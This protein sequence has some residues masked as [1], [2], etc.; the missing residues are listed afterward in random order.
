MLED[1]VF[2]PGDCFIVVAGQR[3]GF[4]VTGVKLRWVWGLRDRTYPHGR[5]VSY[6][7]GTNLSDRCYH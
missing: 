4:R 7:V 6:P 5:R 3:F 1:A 2:L